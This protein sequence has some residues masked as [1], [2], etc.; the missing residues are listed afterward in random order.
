MQRAK[1]YNEALNKINQALSDIGKKRISVD[2]TNFQATKYDAILCTRE[3]GKINIAL[4][5]LEVEATVE[6]WFQDIKENVRYT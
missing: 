6:V 4:Y 2:P 1:A 3:F 5:P